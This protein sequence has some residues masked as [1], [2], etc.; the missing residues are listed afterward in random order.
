MSPRPVIFV[1]PPASFDNPAPCLDDKQYGLGILANA[2]WLKSK[3]F[4]VEG[5]HLPLDRHHG[6]AVGE[7]LDRIIE[8]DPLLV[9]VGLNWV[10]FSD[11]AIETARR[12]KSRAPHLP[13][14]VGGQH[15]SL[16]A[17]EIAGAHA[18]CIDGVIQGEAEVPLLTI[19]RALQETGRIPDDVPGLHRPN[20]PATTQHVVE[21]M[22]AL[23]TYSYR[24]FQSAPLQRDVGALSTT[25]GACPFKCAWC[26]E[27]VIGRLQGRRKLQFHSAGHIVDQMESLIA[28]GIDR[29]TIQ[30]NF[31]VGGNRKLIALADEMERRNVRPKHLNIFSHP[32]SYGAE[33]YA[34]FAG[35]AERASL[36][37]GV[38][39]GS[40][41]VAAINNRRLELDHVVDQTR[42]AVDVGVEV[43]TWWMVGL[44]GEDDAALTETESLILRTMRVGGVPRWVSPLILFPKTPIHDDPET[45]GVTTRFRTFSDYTAFSRTT[46]AEAVLFSDTIGHETKEATR[47]DI[48]A[49]S[50]RLRKFVVA[51]L[52][53]LRD[54]YAE[55]PTKPDLATVEGRVLQSFF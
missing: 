53:I 23:P 44:P 10:H 55:R 52:G 41:R 3:G 26:I 39:T 36:D 19:C 47:D 18:D 16:F 17:A 11:G 29:F 6:K 32:E 54:F 27:P 20:R 14:V 25:R 24:T 4:P 50:L 37:F 5:H 31:F 35:C 51:H 34:A 7:S 49:A 45:F 43:Y 21:D 38:E 33:G 30:D 28:E 1:Q 22:E 15:A 48:T 42:T 8:R 46:L 2:A 40:P 13:I 9:A 12:L